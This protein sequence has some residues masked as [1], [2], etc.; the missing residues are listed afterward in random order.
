MDGVL[1]VTIITCSVGVSGAIGGGFW[2]VWTKIGDQN[3]AIGRLEGKMD[4][5]GTRMHSFEKQ[6]EGF[7]KRI[8]RLDRRLNGFVDT[9]ASKDDSS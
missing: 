9:L 5:V 1:V 7:D 2:K 8:D 3:K 6:M 4:G